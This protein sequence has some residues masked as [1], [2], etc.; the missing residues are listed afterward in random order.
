MFGK[1]LKRLVIYGWHID[2]LVSDPAHAVTYLE[3]AVGMTPAA[4]GAE[5][6]SYGS[7]GDAFFMSKPCMLR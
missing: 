6:F 7:W 1:K 4:M 2:P 3:D 5:S